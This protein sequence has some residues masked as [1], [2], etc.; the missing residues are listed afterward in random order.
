MIQPMIENA[1]SHGLEGMENGGIVLLEIFEQDSDLHIKISDNGKGMTPKEL[2]NLKIRINT[3]DETRTRSIGLYNINQRLH[4]CYG[5]DCQL[6][7]SSIKGQQT[8][9]LLTLPLDKIKEGKQ[10]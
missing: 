2:E 8:S 9:F 6:H 7:I 10:Q 5:S 3:K 4:L 1:I